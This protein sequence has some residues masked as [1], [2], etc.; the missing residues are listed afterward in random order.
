MN[1]TPRRDWNPQ[2]IKQDFPIFQIQQDGKP[3]TY[4]D[5]AATSQKPQIVLDKL[6]DYLSKYCANAHRGVYKIGAVASEEYEGA[7]E[8]VRKFINAKSTKEVIFTAGT[9]E[10]V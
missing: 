3:L 4:L 1:T 2:N 8:K 7:R 9:T 6:N 10:S 5:S